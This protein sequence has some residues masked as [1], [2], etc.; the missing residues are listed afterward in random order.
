M[1]GRRGYSVLTNAIQA[2]KVC[3]SIPT[4]QTITMSVQFDHHQLHYFGILLTNTSPVK[5]P[6]LMPTNQEL[7]LA[8]FYGFDV[9]QILFG[10]TQICEPLWGNTKSTYR[11]DPYPLSSS[12]YQ[13]QPLIFCANQVQILLKKK[14][15]N[16]KY[17]IGAWRKVAS[18]RVLSLSHSFISTPTKMHKCTIM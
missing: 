11:M 12:S 8:W 5:T 17:F 1:F 7:V 16:F 10:A 14:K 3:L 4:P 6:I 18:H 15:T 13:T 2:L 9:V